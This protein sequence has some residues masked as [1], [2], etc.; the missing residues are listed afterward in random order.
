M[1]VPITPD[2]MDDLRNEVAQLRKEL[3]ALAEVVAGRY[4]IADPDLAKAGD[5]GLLRRVIKLEEDAERGK[6]M[7]DA[8]RRK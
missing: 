8:T 6:R 3:A 2:P 7:A 5:E 4:D 1:P